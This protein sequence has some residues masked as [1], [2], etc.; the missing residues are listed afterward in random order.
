MMDKILLWLG[1][2][3]SIITY[4][5][6]PQIKE[7]FGIGIFYTGN[8]LFILLICSYLFSKNRSSLVCFLLFFVAINNLIDELFFDPTKPQ[9]NEII[10]LILMPF[11]WYLKTK[12]NARKINK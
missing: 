1:L 5:L 3:V 2:I 11:I 6:W 9:F 4:S 10:L 12:D 7:Q 8:A